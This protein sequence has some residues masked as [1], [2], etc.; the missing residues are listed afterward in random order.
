MNREM[1]MREVM[2][3]AARSRW[4]AKTC[5]SVEALMAMARMA[6]TASDACAAIAEVCQTAKDRGAAI[7]PEG[8]LAFLK[9]NDLI[10][11][12]KDDEHATAIA[13]D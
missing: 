10:T 12:E 3:R 2:A 11:E 7:N 13:A 9:D 1:D 8:I 5:V 4:F 6:C